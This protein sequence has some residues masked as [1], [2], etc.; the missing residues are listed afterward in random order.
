MISAIFFK[1]NIVYKKTNYKQHM[2]TTGLSSGRGGQTKW[3][4]FSWCF[5]FPNL[6]KT[7]L[8][9]D[10]QHL[11]WKGWSKLIIFTSESWQSSSSECWGIF[12]WILNFTSILMYCKKLFCLELLSMLKEVTVWT[13]RVHCV[14]M[15][16]IHLKEKS[17]VLFKGVW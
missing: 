11:N 16:K 17:F 6:G 14:P 1:K 3:L 10:L 2:K 5:S 7:S 13:G 12:L 9:N 15:K 4:V 8:L